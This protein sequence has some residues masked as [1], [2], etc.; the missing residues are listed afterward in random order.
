MSEAWLC[1]IPLISVSFFSLREESFQRL[2]SLR[3]RCA[4]SMRRISIA[5]T[6]C[7]SIASEH[8]FRRLG[9]ID[10]DSYYHNP[11]L[12]WAG[13]AARMPMN[14]AP[15]QLLNGWV[16]HSRPIGCPETNFGRT[17]KKAL[18]R[19]DLPIVFATWSAIDRK[20]PRWRMQ[21]HFTLMPSP[22]KLRPRRPA[23]RRP[24]S[25]PPTQTPLS[26]AT[27]TGILPLPTHPDLVQ[28]PRPREIRRNTS[29]QPR[30]PLRCP[31]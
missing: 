8:L 9:M 19:N 12:R 7:H 5:H 30:R 16:A 21:A 20:R 1:I 27:C 15:R 3:S 26:P 13:Y 2:Q 31:R 23:L 11:V 22:S 17:V 29:L 6:I 18:K 25:L 28:A 14:R 24:T 10:L 4:R